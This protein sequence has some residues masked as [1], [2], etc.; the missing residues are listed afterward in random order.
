MP[1]RCAMARTSSSLAPRPSSSL[2]RAIKRSTS[3]MAA[4]LPVSGPLG[5]GLGGRSRSSSSAN[6]RAA[7]ASARFKASSIIMLIS[8]IH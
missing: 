6:A 3:N 5:A 4:E 8:S 2:I 1:A 7:A